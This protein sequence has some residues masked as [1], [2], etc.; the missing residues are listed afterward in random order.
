VLDLDFERD[1]LREIIVSSIEGRAEVVE[2]G[3]EMGE[4][5]ASE[6][7]EEGTEESLPPG[8][9]G[10][11]KAGGSGSLNRILSSIE[12]GFSLKRVRRFESGEI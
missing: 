2:A 6:E 11:M 12:G 3:E 9:E 8:E 5:D 7:D 4:F 10:E 1:C